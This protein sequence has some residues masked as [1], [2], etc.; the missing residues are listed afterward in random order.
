M[1]YLLPTFVLISL[2]AV[3]SSAGVIEDFEDVSDW[4][5]QVGGSAA[6]GSISTDAGEAQ[7]GT[8]AGAL[9]YGHTTAQGGDYVHYNKD[10]SSAPINLTGQTIEL[11]LKQPNDPDAYFSLYIYDSNGGMRE[12]YFPEGTGAWQF[13]SIPIGDFVDYGNPADLT[14]ISHIRF[15]S[16]GDISDTATSGTY[17]VDQLEYVPEPAT[18]ALLMLSV[19]FALRRRRV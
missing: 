18:M 11:H 10:L 16:N 14:D 12:Y 19:P 1:I 3:Q 8:Y 6:S 2:L 4:G 17:F 13:L 5:V 9:A 7:V 15:N